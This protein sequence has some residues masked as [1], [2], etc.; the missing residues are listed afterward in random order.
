MKRVTIKQQ[1]MQAIDGKT[2][3]VKEIAKIIN[4]PMAQ[5]YS[6]IAHLTKEKKVVKKGRGIYRDAKEQANSDFMANLSK[7]KK[8]T[9]VNKKAKRKA[10]EQKEVN[11]EYSLSYIKKLEFKVVELHQSVEELTSQNT[12]L[13]IDLLDQTAIINYLEKKLGV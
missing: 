5:V 2:L 8:L 11:S 7:D 9:P 12:A 10:R 3:G 6:A 13:K 1:I 4:R